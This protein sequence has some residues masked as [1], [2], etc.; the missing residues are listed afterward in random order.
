MSFH[1]D[2]EILVCKDQYVIHTSINESLTTSINEGK[3]HIAKGQSS[4]LSHP[5]GKSE[6]LIKPLNFTRQAQEHE[7]S[8]ITLT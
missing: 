4:S 3:K 1:L 8:H 5:I 6:Q 2:T 7:R